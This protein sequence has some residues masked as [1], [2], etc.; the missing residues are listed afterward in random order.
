MS[1]LWDK[2]LSE[3]M[4]RQADNDT[5]YFQGRLAEHQQR[6]QQFSSQDEYSPF[7][8]P[9]QREGYQRI[10]G[11]NYLNNN[12]GQQV[13]LLSQQDNATRRKQTRVCPLKFFSNDM[14]FSAYL[15]ILVANYPEKGEVKK[16]WS[17]VRDQFWVKISQRVSPEVNVPSAQ[18][19]KAYTIQRAEPYVQNLQNGELD[20]K[21]EQETRNPS[22]DRYGIQ[23]DDDLRAVAQHIY[24]DHLGT[25][26]K[27]RKRLQNRKKRWW[28]WAKSR[29]TR[30]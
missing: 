11:Y 17:L 1:F 27:Y 15:E 3:N 6:V 26:A 10:P 20:E 29:L 23:I 18:T 12:N 13:S 21:D 19:C 16:G 25:E 30:R 5:I 4:N 2:E 8:D 24:D 28:P 7:N 14:H 9:A 22:R